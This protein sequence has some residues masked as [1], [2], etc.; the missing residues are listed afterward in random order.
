MQQIPQIPG[1]RIIKQL[2]HGGMADVYLG[3][4]ENL[5][6]EVAIKVLIPALFRDPQ[7]STRFI[8]EAQTAAR[9]VHQNIITIH[10]V[11]QT[12]DCHYIVMEYLQES[13]S[14]RMKQQGKLPPEES[15]G[16][17]RPIASALDYAH[18]K[19]FIHR[20]IKPDNIMFRTDGTVVLVDF[21]I[22]RAMD[23]NTQLTRTG[24][25]IGTPHYMSPEQ[26]KGETIDGRSDIYSLGVEF[27]E[28][29]TGKVPYQAKSTAGVI[30]KHIQEP[31]PRLPEPLS[32]FQPLI[33][34]MMA[35]NPGERIQTGAELVQLIDTVGM[36]RGT[37][38]LRTVVIPPATTSAAEQPTVITSQ[39][40]HPLPDTVQERPPRPRWVMPAVLLTA[41]VLLTATIYI[42][43]RP[44]E[45][46]TPVAKNNLDAIDK[47]SQQETETRKPPTTQVPP[48]TKSVQ[49]VKDKPVPDKK[50]GE[51]E[52]KKKNNEEKPV[53]TEHLKET[54][55]KTPAKTVKAGV[56]IKEENVGE[57]KVKETEVKE[58][59][60][61]K[62]TS[63]LR[64][65][66]EKALRRIEMPVRRRPLQRK[67]ASWVKGSVTLSLTIDEKGAVTAKVT[68]D[69]TEIGSGGQRI[70]PD[71]KRELWGRLKKQLG[72]ISLLP[73]KNKEG[74]PLRVTGW[75]V[76]YSVFKIRNRLI[77][78]M[79]G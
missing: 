61:I 44:A 1:Y 34:R 76:T 35:K 74:E 41:L 5:D 21:G 26:C 18:Q 6:R 32:D 23:S 40:P 77:L 22:A 71:K 65:S 48:K 12:G 75:R 15:L 56:K 31:V 3:V 79:K 68:S 59:S 53:K 54:K 66:Y 69:D 36:E 67:A 16:I 9:L 52:K 47:S 33:D 27:Y 39:P 49:T 19:G 50:E 62:V 2:G 25:S 45:K 13:L 46:D 29:V 64:E 38:F 42:L 20:D 57:G 72:D 30:I 70:Q 7:F 73:P 43:T 37:D 17:I 4:Q 55:K 14:Q 51:G 28:L 8:K 11:G 78:R 10:D 60:I 63:E 58:V 24:M